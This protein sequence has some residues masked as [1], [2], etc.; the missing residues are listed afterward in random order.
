MI[1]TNQLV[2][3]EKPGISRMVERIMKKSKKQLKFQ[4]KRDIIVQ[5][6]L[7]L[8]FEPKE[9]VVEKE[10]KSINVLELTPMDAIN[11]LYKL[12]NKIK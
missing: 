8:D 10:L 3:L 7:P 4:K 6:T 11:L 5:T 1:V 2:P 9:S 12:K